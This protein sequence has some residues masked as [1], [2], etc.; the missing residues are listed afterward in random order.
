MSSKDDRTLGFYAEEAS[1]YAGRDRQAE[2]SR[3]DPFVAGLKRGARVLELGCGGGQDSEEMLRRGFDVMPTDGSPE[4]AAQAEQRLGRPVGVLLF[5]DIEDVA[6]YD[7]VWAHACLLHAPR[8]ALPGIIDR[9]HRAL[10]PGGILY[11][12][13]KAGEAEGRDGLGRYFNYLSSDELR[14]A[15]G[16][17]ARWQSLT[18]DEDTGSGYDRQPTRWLHA[19]A[20]K[21]PEP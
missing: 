15:F 1:A 8:P 20:I 16:N 12:S 2:H 3:I 21:R 11:A 18:I 19:L 14:A 10:R 5:E 4:L 17:G 7:G 13:F 9:I 6:A